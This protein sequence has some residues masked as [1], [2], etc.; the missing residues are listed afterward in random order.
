MENQTREGSV[1]DS[2]SP[3]SGYRQPARELDIRFSQLAP[4]LGL[5]PELGLLALAAAATAQGRR[6]TLR[7]VLR[8]ALDRGA[9]PE[10]LREVLLQTYLF[11]GYPR[12]INALAEMAVLDPGGEGD[13]G[14]DLRAEIGE[15][16]SWVER[17]EA[18]CRRVYGEAYERLL[19]TMARISPDLGRWMIMEGYGKVLSRP[20][21]DARIRELTA[22]AA[23]AVLSVPDQLRAHIRGSFLVGATRGE[24]EGVLA[25]VSL[26]DPRAREEAAPLLDRVAARFEPDA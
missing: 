22:V 8:L 23:L 14:L 12:A 3:T 18:L 5:G 13:T 2:T 21:L 24:I 15:A 7:A 4:T 25:S 17:G 19:P 6:D 1:T 26:I 9:D 20:R 10:A 16:G 11:A